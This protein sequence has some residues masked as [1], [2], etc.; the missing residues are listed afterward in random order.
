M[1]LMLPYYL[2][3]ALNSLLELN[4]DLVI[5]DGVNRIMEMLFVSLTIIFFCVID[6]AGG[7]G[8]LWL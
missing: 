4:V 6:V 8:I 7:G 2:N 5:H 1:I 3:F